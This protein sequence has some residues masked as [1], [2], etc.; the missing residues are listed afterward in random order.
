VVGLLGMVDR[1]EVPPP[2][3]TLVDGGRLLLLGAETDALAGSRWAA[4]NGGARTGSLTPLDGPAVTAVAGL[5]RD[6][7][8]DRLLLGVHDVAE[9]GLG[10]V[11]AEMAVRSGVGVKAARVHDHA[12]LFAEAPGRVVVC[13]AAHTTT[14]VQERA[15]RAGVPV[16]QLGLATGDRISVKDLVDVSLADATAA[17]RDRLP[18]ALGTGVAQA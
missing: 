17:Y 10:V 16:T 12:H 2:G 13:V 4:E 1:L 15:E 3:P 8:I 7:V 5:V 11:L 9:G 14:E 18:Q 6:L